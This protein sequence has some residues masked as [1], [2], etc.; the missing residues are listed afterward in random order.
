MRKYTP[1][2]MGKKSV[3]GEFTI[4]ESSLKE[5]WIN[6]KSEWINDLKH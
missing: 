3:H 6:F 4:D 5:L 1:I 2:Y